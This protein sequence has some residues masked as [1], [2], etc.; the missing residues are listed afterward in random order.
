MSTYIVLPTSHDVT[1]G[2]D[3]AFERRHVSKRRESQE[4]WNLRRVASCR[5]DAR[6]AFIIILRECARDALYVTRRRRRPGFIHPLPPLVASRRRINSPS[7]RDPLG[8]LKRRA[9]RA[10]T[11][12]CESAGDAGTLKFK[13]SVDTSRLINF[14]ARTPAFSLP[15]YCRCRCRHLLPR[16]VLSFFSVPSSPP[17]LIVSLSSAATTGDKLHAHFCPHAETRMSTYSLDTRFL[18]EV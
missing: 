5:R 7:P 3:S 14:R 18:R 2:D 1:V 15:S 9:R 17:P 6:R 12:D 16:R 10:G 8:S 4:R 13:V 11:P